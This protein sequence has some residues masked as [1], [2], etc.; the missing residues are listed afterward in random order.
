MEPGQKTGFLFLTAY[1][2]MQVASLWVSLRLHVSRYLP[3]GGNQM[4]KGS[5]GI[6]QP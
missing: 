2:Q 4:G 1:A 5:L 6:K 3:S